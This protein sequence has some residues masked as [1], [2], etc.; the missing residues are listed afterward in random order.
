MMSSRVLLRSSIIDAVFEIVYD[1][2]ALL[3]QNAAAEFKNFVKLSRFETIADPIKVFK[4]FTKKGNFYGLIEFMV[5]CPGLFWNSSCLEKFHNEGFLSQVIGL[6]AHHVTDKLQIV[7]LLF[8]R[9]K[10][11]KLKLLM[12]TCSELPMES[13]KKFLQTDCKLEPEVYFHFILSSSDFPIYPSIR[14]HEQ[15]ESRMSE[16]SLYADQLF[17]SSEK[18]APLFNCCKEINVL[19]YNLDDWDNPLREAPIFLDFAFNA[20]FRRGQF[21]ES[22]KHLPRQVSISTFKLIVLNQDFSKRLIKEKPE[23]IKKQRSF[24]SLPE[25]YQS[26]HFVM[27][28]STPLTG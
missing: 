22:V 12:L 16:I 27:R 17:Q 15:Y 5:A 18:A 14:N 11:Q 26:L 8:S 3:A 24:G 25:E 2:A 9:S 19:S 20:L 10:L 1:E 23:W 21:D 4:H 7:N 6:V 28:M 13:V